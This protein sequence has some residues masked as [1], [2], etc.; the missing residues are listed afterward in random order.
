[1]GRTQRY[2]PGFN[3]ATARTLPR[4]DPSGYEPGFN[5]ATARTLPCPDPSGYE[6]GFNNAT[7]RTLPRPDPSGYE[8]GFNNATVSMW[9]VCGYKSNPRSHSRLH[10]ASRNQPRSRAN[11]AG[12]HET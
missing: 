7:A 2:E 8:P 1:M 4:P 6:P 12:S 11:E 5:N 10:P 9:C 3:N